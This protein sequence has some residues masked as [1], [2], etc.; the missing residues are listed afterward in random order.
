MKKFT[1]IELLVVIAIIGILSSMLLPSIQKARA[2][3]MA[4]LCISNEKQIGV[5]FMSY[6]SSNDDAFAYGLSIDAVDVGWTLPNDSRPPMEVLWN[7]IGES[8]EVFICPLDPSP[9]DYNFWSFDIMPNFEDENA[10]ASYM[11][12][13]Y[14]AW[15]HPRSVDRPLKFGADLANP[16][17]WPIASDGAVVVSSPSWNRCTPLKVGQWGC[18]DWWHPNSKVAMLFGDGHVDSVSAFTTDTF[19][20]NPVNN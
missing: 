2:A 19:A 11:F 12:N 7:D 17:T 4:S 15:Y 18:L 3:A 14:G 8:N 1:L 16:A 20:A 10:R 13:E 9:E 5:A 6:A